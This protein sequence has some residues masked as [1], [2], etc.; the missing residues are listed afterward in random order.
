M[1]EQ[2]FQG[3]SPEPE[4]QYFLERPRIDR[5]LAKALQ[6]HVVTVI[7]GEGS[8]KTHAVHSFLRKD[9]RPIIWVQLSERDNMGWRFW[10]N[11]T[12]EVAHLN[13]KAAK[14][15][16]DMG[17]PESG[18]QFD[19]YL[20]L[21][22]NE[23]IS[24]ERY[25]IVF[26]DFH[27]L[28]NPSVLLH[29]ER[30]L[31]APVS[32]NTIVFISRTE[33]AMNT[34]GL[35]AKGLL[36]QITAEDL[37]FTREETDEYFRLHHILLAEEELDRICRETEGWALALGLI[38]QE[39][40][41]DQTGGRSW[42]R[43]MLPI[44]KMEENIFSA[45]EAEL[46]KFLIKLSLIEH[47]PRNL[48]E[49]L[50]PGGKHISAMEKFSSVIRFDAYLHGFRIHHLFLDFLR[51]KQEYLS[52]E[53]IREVC[54]KGAQWCIENNLPTDAAVNY[55]R[56]RDYGGFIRLINS[57]PQMLS[58]TVA[59]FFLN[60]AERLLAGNPEDGEDWDFIF[61]RFIIRPRL[62]ALLERFDEAAGECRAA[63]TRFEAQSPSPNRSRILYAAYNNLGLLSILASKYTRDYAFSHW[64][65]QGYRYYLENPEP[66]Q[67][68]MSQSNIGSYVI[69]VGFPAEPGEIES[70][71]AAYSAAVPHIAVSMGGYRFGT[72]TLARAE[73]AYYQG[74]LNKA[75]QFARRAIYQGREKGQYEVENRAL[76]YLM[77]IGI[78][79]GD[80]TEIRDLERQ[81]EAQ[82]EKGEYPNRYNIH[83]IIMGRFYTHLGLI[84]RIAPWL[85]TE[86]EGEELNALFRGFDSL[87]KARYLFIEKDYPSALQ[88]LTEEQAR[89]DLGSSLLGMLEMTALEA[90]I[91][92]GLG[93]REGAF[94]ALKRAYDAA[95]HHTLHIPFIELGEPMS[96]LIN[97]LLKARG[98]KQGD[99]ESPDASNGIPEEWLHTIRRDASA[100]AK[101]R[102]LVAAQYSGRDT[103]KVPAFSEW[104][105]EILNS[106]SQ[107]RTAEELAAGL[108]ISVK[109]VKSA[110]RSV[111]TKLGAVN[112]ADAIRSATSKGLLTGPDMP[113]PPENG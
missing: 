63:I 85:R 113:K 5:L 42:D 93:D 104:E 52:R 87:V 62:L 21:V 96:G 111:Y 65:E 1:S 70:F 90:V 3:M 6:S 57:L 17:F 7:A 89:G 92:H 71:I 50:E 23:I 9:Q 36:F 88:V 31:A 19:R 20:G 58:R 91:R 34:L 12:G 16:A 75:E 107:G 11:Y 32:K 55:E 27:L 84:E 64:F 66:V 46:Q 109:M 28:T 95:C 86:N 81:M 40:K 80:I 110:I 2:L 73:L 98:E 59:S 30:A 72:D 43:V 61:L 112:R 97:A 13:P 68:M 45:M 67:G 48:L 35:L 25:V 18:R 4:N 102:S 69:P 24:R 83:D 53:E 103:A 79:R 47:W 29:L 94:S 44:K 60:T 15:F 49:R 74:D 54:S 105:R 108:N 101:K 100:Y 56:A 26:D 82:M 51:E 37:R 78:H 38:L 8:G 14:I 106:L 10:E 99:R 41:T 39:I 22:K 33:P 76:F 77:R